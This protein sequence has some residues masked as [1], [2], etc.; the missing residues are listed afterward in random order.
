MD[1]LEQFPDLRISE[2]TTKN[3]AQTVCF[4]LEDER[5]ARDEGETEVKP[6]RNEECAQS[7]A[8]IVWTQN[9]VFGEDQVRV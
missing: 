4:D 6:N 9:K 3:A 5:L 7:E 1:T 2:C 8:R